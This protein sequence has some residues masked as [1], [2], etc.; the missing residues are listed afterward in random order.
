MPDMPDPTPWLLEIADESGAAQRVPLRKPRLVIGRAAEADL[1]LDRQS[2]SRE[3]AQLTLEPDGSWKLLDLGSRG[4]CF[5]NGQKITE[6]TV[7]PADT[8]TISRFQLRLVPAGDTASRRRGFGGR[9]SAEPEESHLSVLTKIESPRL[10]SSHIVALSEFG[11]ELLTVEPAASRLEKLCEVMAGRIIRARWAMA[12][13]VDAADPNQP[14]RQLAAFPHDVNDRDVHLSRSAILGM[15]SA[16][17]PVLATNFRKDD[18]AAELSMVAKSPATAVVVCALSEDPGRT[19][20]LYVNL[21]P[22]YGSTEWLAL[23]ALAVKQYQQAEAVWQARE[24]ARAQAAVERDLANARQ[25]QRSILPKAKPTAGLEIAWSFE[26]CEQVGGDLVD[27]VP[28]PDGRVLLVIADV[29]G[30]GMP[31]A[32]ATLAVHS[33][34]HVCIRSGMS[35]AKTMQTLNDHLCEYSP[36]GKFVT[37][38]CVAI[39][40]GTGAMQCINAGH[41][42]P[43]ILGRGGGSRVLQEAEHLPL[44]LAPGEFETQGERLEAGDVLLLSTDGLTELRPPGGKMLGAKGVGKLLAESVEPNPSLADAAASLR[45]KILDVQAQQPAADDQTFLMVRLAPPAPSPPGRGPG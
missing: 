7:G 32:L 45:K 18:G 20:V 28:M 19:D 2:V 22:I 12:L 27:V 41:H 25:I 8:F 40:P 43:V 21:P 5:V 30:H 4:G 16:R 39:D 34:V 37:M 26:P 17:A 35:L 44:G 6:A 29:T 24:A 13:R 14:L 31:A 9:W 11:R 15:Q 23:I 36:E 42:A 38:V 3:H 10:D 33:I 1:R